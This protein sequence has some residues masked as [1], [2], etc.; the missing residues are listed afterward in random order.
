MTTFIQHAAAFNPDLPVGSLVALEASL[1]AGQDWVEIDIIPLAGG[2]FA[3]LH[4][5]TLQDGTEGSGKVI[6]KS[7]DEIRNLR[8]LQADG[9]P[10]DLHLGTL[11]QAL[12]LLKSAGEEITLQLD[13]KPYAALTP[14]VLGGLYHMIADQ[15]Q[16]ILIS[17]VADWA[18]RILHQLDGYLRLGFDP[19]LYL[20]IVAS[21]P[22]EQGVP[23]LRC[24]AYGYLDDHPLAI[25]R[26]GSLKDYFTMRAEAL[27]R[28]A[29]PQSTW[30]IN[31]SLLD[32]AQQAGFD[33]I[34]FL[35]SHGCQVDA[36]TLDVDRWQVAQ[37][38]QSQGIDLITSNQPGQ[39]SQLLKNIKKI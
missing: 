23:P 26:W 10:N 3:L 15:R 35:Q 18:L 8:Y 19:L 21:E 33:W 29:P 7:A 2:D 30:F 6:E 32:D 25:E 5:P 39:L 22:R 16:Q 13:L 4:Q 37:R 17:C 31:A 1:N 12:V 27:L 20:D 36:W 24:G 28:Q 34:K 14:Q 11:S 9:S 38:L